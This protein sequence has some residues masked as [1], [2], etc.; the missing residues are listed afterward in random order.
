LRIIVKRST[1]FYDD[2]Q[3]RKDRDQADDDRRKM[4]IHKN[5][6]VETENSFYEIS[7]VKIRG[8]EDTILFFPPK[9]ERILLSFDHFLKECI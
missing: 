9:Q 8:F 3:Q 6:I 5:N 2:H 4:C 7:K 1:L